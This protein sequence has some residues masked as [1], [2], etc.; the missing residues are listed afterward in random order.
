[1]NSPRILRKRYIPDEVVDISGDEILYLD[2]KLMVTKWNVIHP[3]ED[4]SGGI[5]FSFL[6]RGYKISRFNRKDGGFAYWYCDIVDIYIDR[7]SNTYTFI[8]LLAD[9][10]IMPDGRVIVLDIEEIAEALE[11]SLI[12]QSQACDAL[13]KLAGLLD[14]IY[15]GEFPPNPIQQFLVENNI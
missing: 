14:M 2:E 13:R 1:M 4:I 6:D 10:K 3:R 12:S 5:S 7:K 11:K 8:D 9:V 15:K